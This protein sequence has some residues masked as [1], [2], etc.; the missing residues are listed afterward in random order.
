MFRGKEKYL[1]LFQKKRTQ[2]QNTLIKKTLEFT[3][4]LAA[5][6]C[7]NYSSMCMALLIQIKR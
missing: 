4:E 3:I 7:T 6:T 5:N 1:I 2:H